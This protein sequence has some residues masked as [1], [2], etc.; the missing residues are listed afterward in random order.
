MGVHGDQIMQAINLILD[1]E[2]YSV[3]VK[4]QALCI[5]ANIADGDAAKDCIMSNDEILGK[6]SN[7]MMH[8]NTKLQIAAVFCISNL[9]WAEEDGAQERQERLRKL[10]VHKKL[11]QLLDT[12]ETALFDKVKTALQQFG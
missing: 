3:E 5:L 9:S 2:Q 4:E 8:S 6:L 7:F 12:K 1:G 11:Q 10:G